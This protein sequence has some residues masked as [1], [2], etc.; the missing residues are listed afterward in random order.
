MRTDPKFE[1][2]KPIRERIN[3]DIQIITEARDHYEELG[4]AHFVAFN[5]ML[6]EIN[7][8]ITDDLERV[9]ESIDK[10]TQTE[11]AEKNKAVNETN[12]AKNKAKKEEA[13]E[14]EEEQLGITSN[15]NK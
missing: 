15:N 5:T 1:T 3:N 11:V 12:E 6:K 9:E 8:A 14:A 2:L 7:M 13:E 4:S 10:D